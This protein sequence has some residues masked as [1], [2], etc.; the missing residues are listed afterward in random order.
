MQ[1]SWLSVGRVSR[2]RGFTM[3]E[4]LV[5]VS[6]VAI[7][8]ALTGPSVLEMVQAQR[9]R[10][11]HAQLNTDLHFAR[12]EAVRLKVP[13]HVA[14][15]SKSASSP[16]CYIVFS[17]TVAARPFSTACD[18][19]QPAGS[20]CTSATTQEIKSVELESWTGI[21]LKAL[22]DTRTG[23]DPFSGTIIVGVDDLGNTVGTSLV[24]EA[25]LDD[26]RVLRSSMD[27]G[28]VV[29]GCSP[30]GSTVRTVT[31]P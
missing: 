13:V 14:V 30:A 29:R 12:S 23:I 19:R 20:R 10:G 8:M 17:D 15:W 24:V 21:D 5:V 28:G 11:V 18:C 7:L 16:A 31:C 4:L 9:L 26:S 22:Q 3:I 6:V 27:I 2:V 25:S 1:T